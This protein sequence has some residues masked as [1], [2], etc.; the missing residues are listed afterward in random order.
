MFN[1]LNPYKLLFYLKNMS[2]DNNLP[3]RVKVTVPLDKIIAPTLESEIFNKGE[4]IPSNF[5]FQTNERILFSS[6][7]TEVL[8]GTPSGN[9]LYGRLKEPVAS[10]DEQKNLP[11]LKCEYMKINK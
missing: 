8:I 7:A 3:D 11:I 4:F 2:G 9:Q 5:Q 1:Y 10:I 6:L